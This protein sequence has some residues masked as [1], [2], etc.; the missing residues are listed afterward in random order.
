LRIW[1]NC[2]ELEA[3]RFHRS[4]RGRVAGEAAGD[5]RLSFLEDRTV[6]HTFRRPAAEVTRAPA[7]DPQPIVADEEK[8]DGT[9]GHAVRACAQWRRSHEH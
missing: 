6:K 3:R 4:G 5:D 9:R 8:S 7:V 1:V 2:R